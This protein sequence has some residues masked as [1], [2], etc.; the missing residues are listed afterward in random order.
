MYS[1][2]CDVVCVFPVMVVVLG[3]LATSTNCR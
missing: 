1:K 3:C 2:V